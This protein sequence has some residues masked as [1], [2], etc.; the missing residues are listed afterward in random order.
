MGE[1]KRI[2]EIKESVD[3]LAQKTSP[4]VLKEIVKD[5]PRILDVPVDY[6]DLE[7]LSSFKVGRKYWRNGKSSYEN[8]KINF[9]FIPSD[10][11]RVRWESDAFPKLSGLLT[12]LKRRYG[13]DGFEIIFFRTK[14]PKPFYFEKLHTKTNVYVNMD[15]YMEYHSV[16]NPEINNLKISKYFRRIKF[17][18]SKKVVIAFFKNKPPSS[19]IEDLRKSNY[20]IIENII[21]EY[22]SM[23]ENEK[24]DLKTVFE[25]SGL[26]NDTIEEFKN[27]KPDSP[28]KQLKLFMKVLEE[29]TSAEI[30]AL[31][32]GLLKSKTS[33]K[34]FNAITNLPAKDKTRI[35]KHL[36]D[37]VIMHEHYQQLEKSLKEF[38]K[39]I[40]EHVDSRRKD[41]KAIHQLL[42]KDCWL[43][44]I[45][46][47]G[48]EIRSDIDRYGKR[49]GDTNIGR[50]RA[51]FIILQRLDGLDTC[52]VIEIEE[53]ND[54]IFNLNGTI[55]KEVYDGIVQ[56]ADYIL[57]QKFRGTHSKGLAIIGSLKALNLSPE[58][59]KRLHLLSEII[60]N[61]EVLTYDQ[62][63]AKA[64]ASL[65]F[66]KK[67]H[68]QN[69]NGF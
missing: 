32:E 20:K 45:E 31:L 64:E 9:A 59:K 67:T 10:D 4:D 69:T 2:D 53:A 48:R 41:E 60:P 29:L 17:E 36:P 55:S 58:E 8:K 13:L 3:E 50:K 43:L 38:K 30:E 52:V 44:G 49:T 63:I 61:V 14:K 12:F 65:R 42:A 19:L 23:D 47:F 26:A 66:W 15:L 11:E 51:D 34:L 7:I 35:S 37:M 68:D 56:A 22:E 33:R 62:I 16:I 24:Q 46:Y 54:R 28:K 27:L 25:H 6:A 18:Y 39:K 5:A 1:E 40:K 21:R 57:E